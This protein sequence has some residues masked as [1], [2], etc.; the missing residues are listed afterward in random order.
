MNCDFVLGSTAEIERLW[1]V[2]KNIMSGK[3]TSMNPLLLESLLFLK[4]NKDYWDL[5]LVS[6]AMNSARSERV[7]S[8]VREHN[9]H[10]ELN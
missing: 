2:A 6:A 1:S 10:E 3:R 8:R 4:Q 9:A 5:L 7:K